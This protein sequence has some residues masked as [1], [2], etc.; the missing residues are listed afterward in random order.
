MA[1]EVCMVFSSTV[2][3]F[4]FLPLVLAGYYN[5]FWKGRAFRN[6]FLLLASL[7]FYAWGEPVF[8]FIMALSIAVNWALV[9]A[10]ARHEEQRRRKRWL[11]AAIGFDVALLVVFKYASFIARNMGML[12][13]N[14]SIA[15]NIALPIGISFFTFQIMSYVFDVYYRKA[16]AQ[17]SLVNLALYISMF[18]QLIAGPIVRYQTVAAEIER[19]AENA[20]DF[21]D[22]MTRFAIGLGKK[23]LI[24]NYA[25]FIADRLFALDGLSVASAWLGALAYSL[26][27]YFDFSGYSDMAIGLGRLFG[28]HFLENFDYPYTAISITDFWRRWHISLSAWFR[29]YVY[30]PLGGNRVA[31]PRLVLNLLAVWLLTGIWH[32]ANWTFV[33]WGL[34][35]FALIAIERFTGFATRLNSRRLS[36]VARA[37]TLVCVLLLWVLFRAESLPLAGRY[38][39]ALFGFGATGFID[40]T[41]WLYLSNGKWVLLASVLLST[42]VARR[43]GAALRS[44]AYPPRCS[45]IPARVRAV[46][47]DAVFGV[48]SGMYQGGV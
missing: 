26:Q 22:G 19:R 42:P 25:G 41:F 39:A 35:Y 43:C 1:Q 48:A 24:A 10:M 21:A 13:G 3:L 14:G 44:G 4:L 12:L 27:I 5:P 20:S 18:P 33:V 45:R 47:D 32:G 15:L 31:K 38:I 29:D 36:A 8:V 2:F 37:Y 40:E 23:L 6:A 11:V 7:G 9:L 17:T 46:R 28:F 34:A 30:I 16:T